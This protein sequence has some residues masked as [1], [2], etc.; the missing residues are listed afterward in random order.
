MVDK[1]N[2]MDLVH[3]DNEALVKQISELLDNARKYVATTVNTALIQT[4]W[5][6]GKIIYNDIQHQGLDSQYAKQTIVNLSKKL[7]NKYGKGFGKSNIYSMLIFYK[8]YPI[9]Q[10]VS[11]QLSWSHY[12]ELIQ[13]DFEPK[14]KFYERECE[15]AHWSVRE[16]RRQ[17]ASELFERVLIARKTN[18]QDEII[19]LANRGIEITKP[20]DII[21]N[22]YVLEF[23]D[24]KEAKPKY[25][26][27]LEKAL[28]NEIEK[29]MLELGKGFMFVGTQQRISIGNDHYFVDMV[30]YNKILRRY[31][32]IEL[33][34]SKFVPSSVGQINQYLNY[35]KKEVND[36]FDKDPIGIILCKDGVKPGIEYALEGINNNIFAANFTTIMPSQLE[37]QEQVDRVIEKF[38]KNRK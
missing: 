26:R 25:E 5:N 34:N 13:I 38:S 35:Y 32:L 30:F 7:T 14:R 11:G 10:T 4:Y 28:V 3:V 36:E 16:L 8:D 23:L 24:G 22:P 2:D 21:K 9:F 33:K 15:N 17:I 18:K 31:V 20:S 19:K 37:L 12:L 29:F 1:T 6:V 27:D